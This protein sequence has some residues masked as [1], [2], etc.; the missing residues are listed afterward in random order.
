[1]TPMSLPPNASLDIAHLIQ[2]AVGPVFLLSGI[3]TTLNVLMGRLARVIDRARLIEERPPVEPQQA[4]ALQTE[5]RVLA[6]RA[7]FIN[8]AISLTTLSALLVALTVV[9]LFANPLISSDLLDFDR[10]R[11]RRGSGRPGRRVDQLSDRGE[12]RDRGAAHRRNRPI[13]NGA[14]RTRYFPGPAGTRDHTRQ[15]PRRAKKCIRIST[16]SCGALRSG[17][18][19]CCSRA[20]CTFL[21]AA[22]AHAANVTILN[23]S[24]DPTRELYEDYNAAFAKYWKAKTGDDVKI[25]QSQG[26]SGKQARAII[27]GLAAD[28]ATLAL[29]FDIDALNVQAQLIPANWQTRLPDHSSPY[30]STIVFLVRHGNPKNI[31]DWGDL[32]KPGVA[33]VTPKPENVGRCALE[34]SRSLGLGAASSPGGLTRPRKLF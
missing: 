20:H 7:R 2:T 5:L 19:R 16:G 27:D 13:R 31:R 29:G 1:M 28:V 14:I 12:D 17:S 3:A 11:I 32:A 30:T 9:L 26:G 25:N 6:R 10:C 23:V 22:P 15:T 21:G 18:R 33:V 24:Y 4:R 34:L 8:A